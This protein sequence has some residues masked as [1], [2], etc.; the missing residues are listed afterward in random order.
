QIFEV[1]LGENHLEEFKISRYDVD[2]HPELDLFIKEDLDP[3]YAINY[4]RANFF[5]VEGLDVQDLYLC[6]SHSL[7]APPVA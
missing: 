7:R 2:Y 1:D 4:T 6:G 3:V 5:A